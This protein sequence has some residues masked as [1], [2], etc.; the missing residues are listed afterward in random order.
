MEMNGKEFA[1]LTR[2]SNMSNDQEKFLGTNQTLF[3]EPL[4]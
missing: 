2:M 1:Q 4:K 3:I